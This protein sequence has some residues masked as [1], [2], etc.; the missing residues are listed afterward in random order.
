MEAPVLTFFVMLCLAS[1]PLIGQGIQP[2]LPGFKPTFEK[3]LFLSQ[4]QAKSPVFEP[5]KLPKGAIFC[6]MEAS[7]WRKTNV[8]IKLRAGNDEMYRKLIGAH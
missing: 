5:Y 1:K 8:W 6:R 2:V 4:N 3:G 7:V